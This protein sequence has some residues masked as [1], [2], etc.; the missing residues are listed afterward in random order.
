METNRASRTAMFT[1]TLRGQHRQR[2]ARPWVFDD[3]YALS[4]VG[5]AWPQIHAQLL[6]LFGETI[7]EEVLGGIC[8]RARHVEERLAAGQFTQ[9][10]ILG[11]G[12]DSFAWRRPDLLKSL[13]VFEVD[14]PASQA[15][16]RERAQTLA[17][18][19][20]DQHIFAPID[21]ETT[22]L[23]EGLGAVGFDASQRTFYSC[24]GVL[25]YLKA[26]AI[27]TLLRTVAAG[28]AGSEIV[29]T[30]QVTPAFL[31]D[32]GKKF[33]DIFTAVAVESGEGFQSVF[34]PAE[35]QVL[36]ERCGLQVAEDLSRDALHDRYFAQRSDG[37]RPFAVERLIA[38]VVR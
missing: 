9:F 29:A 22:S 13:R 18:P 25:I 6:A 30:Y 1:A 21:F 28:A 26:D 27:Q 33:W 24:L 38:A 8:C 7:F 16:K 2:H 17:L 5:P 10:V 14:H 34:A 20:S 32:N 19:L 3:P 37:L 12:M 4:L 36:V 31:D 35:I 15:W 23:R 11:A